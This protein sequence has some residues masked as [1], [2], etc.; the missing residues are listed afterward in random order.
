MYE[1]QR[2][3][4]RVPVDLEAQIISADLM[5][6]GKTRVISLK[7]MYTYSSHRLPV[8]AECQ[9]TLFLAGRG[10]EPQIRAVGRIV[11]IDDSGMGIEFTGVEGESFHHLRNLVLYHAE[12]TERIEREFAS[13]I[14]LK[15]RE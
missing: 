7:G 5:I 12:D 6:E 4:T 8:N 11:H 1:E 9:I 13:H 2:E 10:N 15:R 3:F 14:G